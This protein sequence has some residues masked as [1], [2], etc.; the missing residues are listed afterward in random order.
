MFLVLVVHADYFS[1]GAPSKAEIGIAP[2]SSIIRIFFE[3]CSIACV[4]IFVLISG[5]FGIRPTLK[6]LGSFVFQCCYFLFGIYA[7]MLVTGMTEFSVR[8]LASCF[9]VLEWNWFIKA[10]LLLYILSPVINS[11]CK[12]ENYKAMKM[13][14]IAFFLFQTI[15]G[16]LTP[17]SKFFESGYSTISFI[18]LYLLARYCK[19]FSPKAVNFNRQTDALIIISLILIIT[20]LEYLHIRFGL[21][22]TVMAYSNPFVILLGMYTLILFSKFTFQS[23]AINWIAASSFAVF[24]LH[25]NYSTCRPYFSVHINQIYN[26]FDGLSCLSII[27]IY[28][29]I[30]FVFAILLDQPRK[31]LF[32]RFMKDKLVLIDDKHRG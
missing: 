28:L 24:L 20:G 11:F 27:L 17:G 19:L 25:T 8:G 21:P 6:G 31:W 18:G 7:I 26:R 32:N 23:K 16:W 10:Y 3:S 22:I 1:L 14:I 5:W 15:Y 12:V 29:I 30:V 2:I 9:L 4:N 13:V